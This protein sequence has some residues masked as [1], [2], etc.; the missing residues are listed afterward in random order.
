[1]TISRPPIGPSKNLPAFGGDQP[2]PSEGPI[3]TAYRCPQGH[4]AESN[5]VRINA[6]EDL[7]DIEVEAWCCGCWSLAPVHEDRITQDDLAKETAAQLRALVAAL[8]E[9]VEQS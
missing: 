6:D 7:G 8:T 5:S 4:L 9:L 3:L 2:T 1:V